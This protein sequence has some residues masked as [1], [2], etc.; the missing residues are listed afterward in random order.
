LPVHRM[1]SSLYLTIL[2]QIFLS[3]LL[4]SHLVE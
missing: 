1:Y 3:S 4:M 2:L